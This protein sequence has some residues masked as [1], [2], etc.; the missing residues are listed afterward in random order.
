VND[1]VSDAIRLR[2]Q[3]DAEYIREKLGV[4]LFSQLRGS[5][6][7]AEFRRGS[8]ARAYGLYEQAVVDQ[9]P[10]P[11]ITGLGLLVLQRAL[12]ACEDLGALLHALAG[13]QH[14]MRFTSYTAEDLDLTFAALRS[15]QLDVRELW[16]MPTD[17]SLT[18]EPDLDDIQRAAMRSL[19]ELSA[20]DIEGQLDAVAHFWEINRASVKNVMHGFSVVPAEF[21]IEPPGAG[22]LSEQVDLGTERPFAASLVSEL[23]ETTRTVATTTYAIDLTPT[24]VGAV[25]DAAEIACELSD[26][27]AEAWRVALSTN[28]LF[29]LRKDLIEQLSAEEQAT[30]AGLEEVP[31]AETA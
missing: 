8:V 25:R 13:E 4:E 17:E 23:D 20:E 3:G 12:L 1:R 7:V 15:R 9:K 28:N 29:V 16:S 11:E 6:R 19:R 22:V 31:G 26:R 27:L 18:I 24:A 5:P 10:E 21:L 30:I 2:T 14:W